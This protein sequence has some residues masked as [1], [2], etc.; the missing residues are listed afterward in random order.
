M[1]HRENFALGELGGLF[2]DDDGHIPSIPDRSRSQG[3]SDAHRHLEFLLG[4]IVRR[5]EAQGDHE[6]TTTGLLEL[7]HHVGAG[8]CRALPMDI[9]AL[10]A[11]DVLS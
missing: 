11:R 10:I 4:G 1:P 2:A 6:M 3:A 8:L 5:G 9:A 7:T